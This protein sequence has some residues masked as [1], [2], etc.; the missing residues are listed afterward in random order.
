MNLVSSFYHAL[1]DVQARA[2]INSMLIYANLVEKSASKL[3]LV[4]MMALGI[5][6]TMVYQLSSNIS[7][8]FIHQ[9]NI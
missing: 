4:H 5:L 2:R 7:I 6:N 3:I 1:Q 8:F 9:D